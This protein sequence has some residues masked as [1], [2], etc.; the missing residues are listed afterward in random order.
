MDRNTGRPRGFAF[1]EFGDETAAAE[2]LRKYDGHE[3]KGRKLRVS[4]AEER[5]RAPAPSSFEGGSQ[6]SSYNS[7][8][9]AKPKGSRK[10]LRGRKRSL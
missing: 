7:P 5:R 10:N 9:V 2:A 6:Q 8:R 1:I 4:E 3:L